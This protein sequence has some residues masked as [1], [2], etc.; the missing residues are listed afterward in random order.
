M[1][2]ENERK[3]VFFFVGGFVIVWESKKNIKRLRMNIIYNMLCKT[4]KKE[5]LNIIFKFL[6]SLKSVIDLV[7]ICWFNIWNLYAKL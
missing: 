2:R 3:I 7:R 1:G 5:E 6:F 4:K